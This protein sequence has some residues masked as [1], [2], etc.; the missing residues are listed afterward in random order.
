MDAGL[1]RRVA[2]WLTEQFFAVELED[3]VIDER[4]AEMPA[5]PKRLADRR[6]AYPPPWHLRV[7]PKGDGNRLD[8]SQLEVIGEHPDARALRIGGLDQATFERLVASLEPLAALG[9]LRALA[10][11][12]KRIDDGRIEP[13]AELTALEALTFRL[14]MFTTRQVAWL[15]VRLPSSLLSESLARSGSSSQRLPRT[16]TMSFSSASANRS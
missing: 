15:R 11:D 7:M 3:L 8:T 13:V 6:V 9:G 16:T 4:F 12:A 10:F 14:S 5:E 1:A 2:D